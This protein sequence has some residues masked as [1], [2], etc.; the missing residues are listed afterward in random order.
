MLTPLFGIP[1]HFKFET[2]N[3]TIVIVVVA[4]AMDTPSLQALQCRARAAQHAAL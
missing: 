3:G 1:I 2:Q 4:Q